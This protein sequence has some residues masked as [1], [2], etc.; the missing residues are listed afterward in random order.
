[1]YMLRLLT[2]EMKLK[3]S[4]YKTNSREFNSIR[5]KFTVPLKHA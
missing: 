1:M 3:L 5:A 2:N 4:F